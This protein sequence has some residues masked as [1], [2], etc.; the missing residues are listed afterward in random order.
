MLHCAFCVVAN[1]PSVLM[2]GDLLAIQLWVLVEVLRIEE[3][4]LVI[5]LAQEVLH[6]D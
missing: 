6:G 1:V 3:L 5:L 2:H 4:V